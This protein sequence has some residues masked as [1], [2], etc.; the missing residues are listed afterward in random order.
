MEKYKQSMKHSETNKAN[1]FSGSQN[2]FIFS[3]S[4]EG[5]NFFLVAFLIFPNK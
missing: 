2:F 4:L 1:H 5:G 3:S